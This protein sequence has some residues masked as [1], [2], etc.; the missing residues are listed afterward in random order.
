M[1]EF[2]RGVRGGETG[3][4]NVDETRLAA[5]LEYIDLTDL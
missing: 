2:E 4:L 3:D 1:N 5:R